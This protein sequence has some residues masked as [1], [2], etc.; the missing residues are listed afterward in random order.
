MQHAE[1]R[2]VEV[3][4]PANRRRLAGLLCSVI[5]DCDSSGLQ[6]P[7]IFIEASPS[8]E[9]QQAGKDQVFGNLGSTD[10]ALAPIS[11]RVDVCSCQAS[12]IPGPETP[13]ERH[14]LILPYRFELI[15][16]AAA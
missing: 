8:T 14:S 7:R 5:D 13:R 12:S 9:T 6:F 4:K 1:R 11:N 2:W 3:G 10:R 16:D 15:R